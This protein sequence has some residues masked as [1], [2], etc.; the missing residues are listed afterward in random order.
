MSR[1][2]CVGS[3]MLSGLQNSNKSHIEALGTRKRNRERGTALQ[4]QQS[5]CK[6]YIRLC[7][8]MSSRVPP[9]RNL[10]HHSLTC[11]LPGGD[12]GRGDAGLKAEEDLG[13]Y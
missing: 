9:T 13:R 7:L 8:D 4:R 10:S 2:H 5:Y 11:L 12:L 3:D 6:F 1:V